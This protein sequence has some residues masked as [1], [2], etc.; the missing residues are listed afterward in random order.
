LVGKPEGK[1]LLGRRRRRL[2]DNIRKDLREIG[3]EVVD[4][5]RLTQDMDQWRVLVEMVMNFWVPQKPGKVFT[6]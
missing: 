1:K 3:W 6:S 4:C 5:T 2:E